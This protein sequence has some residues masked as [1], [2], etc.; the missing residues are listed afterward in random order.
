MRRV[1]GAYLQALLLL[2]K[3][4][5][6][7]ISKD[8]HL[9]L[10]GGFPAWQAAYPPG[11]PPGG[12]F[13]D[14]EVQSGVGMEVE[15]LY[16][17]PTCEGHYQAPIKQLSLW[18]LYPSPRSTN[19]LLAPHQKK[20]KARITL[21]PHCVAPGARKIDSNLFYHRRARINKVIPK[22]NSPQNRR[23]FF[24]CSQPGDRQCGTIS[25]YSKLLAIIIHHPWD[26]N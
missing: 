17:S 21:L 1:E 5:G 26:H 8:P 18:Q 6:P 24:H 13:R 7:S 10:Q 4:E 3:R 19:T 25:N 11:H 12:L 20:K 15:G 9:K 23:A 2:R 14:W 16:F 22:R